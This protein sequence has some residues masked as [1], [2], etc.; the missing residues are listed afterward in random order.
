RRGPLPQTGPGLWKTK[1]P[2]P[3]TEWGARKQLP[4][5]ESRCRCRPGAQG[6]VAER[7]EDGTGMVASAP[8]VDMGPGLPATACR[9]CRTATSHDE[10]F[11]LALFCVTVGSA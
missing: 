5:R 2:R 3:R 9:K 11:P 7:A 8:R 10:L 1:R 6:P 4:F